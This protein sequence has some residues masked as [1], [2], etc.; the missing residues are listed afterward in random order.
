MVKVTA[1]DRGEP[2]SMASL[3]IDTGATFG[4]FVEFS[5]DAASLVF[6]V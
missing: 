2:G 5:V 4:V 1:D 3:G 6:G